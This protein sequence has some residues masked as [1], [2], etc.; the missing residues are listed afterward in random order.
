M[1]EY[2]VEVVEHVRANIIL[3]SLAELRLVLWA[4]LIELFRDLVD[5]GGIDDFIER[6]ERRRADL[7]HDAIE[8]GIWCEDVNRAELLRRIMIRNT[9]AAFDVR[10]RK[11]L[12]T[13]LLVVL[14]F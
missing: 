3:V 1:K 4:F 13:V 9:H 10:V 12:L 2:V 6:L 5:D 11:H 14:D 7:M 8:F